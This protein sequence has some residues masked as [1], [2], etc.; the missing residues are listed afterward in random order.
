METECPVDKRTREDRLGRQRSVVRT[1]VQWWSDD[2]ED[3]PSTHMAT[4]F[5]LDRAP[6]EQRRVTVAMADSRRPIVLRDKH[7]VTM[8][9][10]AE[11]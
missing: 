3:G 2:D 10:C 1:T 6:A 11:S 4:Q 9:P 8:L 7:T 5:P